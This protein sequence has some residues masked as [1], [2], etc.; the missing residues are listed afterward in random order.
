MSEEL[1]KETTEIKDD[2]TETHITKRRPRSIGRWLLYAV[3]SLVILLVLIALVAMLMLRTG[4]L[5]G[6]V[7]EQFI[8]KLNEIGVDFSADRFNVQTSPLELQ[9]ENGR[10]K[11]HKTGEDLLAVKKATIGL[12]V[13]DLFKWS[14]S[15]DISIDTTEVDGA[16]LW[17]KVDENG[18]SNFSDLNLVQKEGEGAVNFRYDSTR[19]TI[20]DSIVHFG[21]LSR[22]ISADANELNISLSPYTETVLG[23]GEE[24]LIDITSKKSTFQYGDSLI[25]DVSL[26]ASG[27]GR[28]DGFDLRQMVLTT[29]LGD[30][31]AKG[32]LSDFQSPKYDF[33]IDSNLDT[34]QAS[35]IFPVGASLKGFGTVK[36]HLTGEGETYKFEGDLTTEALRADGVYLKGADI[37]GTIMGTNSSYEANGKAVAELL[38]FDDFRLDMLKLA[39]N[40]RGTG[41]DFKWFGDLEAAAAK[42]G[43]LSI[44]G[45]YLRDALAEKRDREIR[46]SSSDGRAQKFAIGDTE[47]E[48]LRTRN[49]RFA[50]PDNNLDIRAENAT[51]KAFNT[52][53]YKLDQITGRN[54]VVQRKNGETSVT[55]AGLTSESSNIADADIKGLKAAEFKFIDRPLTTD[56]ELKG[57]TANRVN[58]DG[59]IIENPSA[60][61]ITINDDPQKTVI[62]SDATRVASVDAGGAVLGSMNVAGVRLLIK[63]GTVT[64]TS[65]DINAGTVDI[66]RSEAMANG[67]KLKEVTFKRP[68]FVVESGSRY[69]AT[70]DMSI[71][72]GTLGS[73]ALG[74]ATAKVTVDNDKAQLSDLKAS[75]MDGSI[76]GSLTYG[77][78]RRTTS[79]IDADFTDV[80]LSKLIA[81]N[82]GRAIPLEGRTRGLVALT[83]PGKDYRSASGNIDIKIAANTVGDETEKIPLNGDI[84]VA[85]VNGLF[86]IDTARLTTGMSEI[87]ATGRL[88]L[89]DNDTD[90]NVSL[91]SK[92][93]DEVQRLIKVSGLVPDLERRLDEM[94]IKA[95]GLMTFNGS[96]KGNIFDPL[97]EGRASLDQVS[98]SGRSLGSVAADIVSN[99]EGFRLNNGILNDGTGGT[100]NFDVNVPSIGT[101]NTTVNA[102]LNNVSA[103]GLLAALPI[104]LPKRIA[105]LSGRATGNVD[106]AGLPN[107]SIGNVDLRV[108][109]GLVAGQHFDE[110]TAKVSF[111]D[112]KIIVDDVRLKADGGELTANGNYDRGTDLFD[113]SAKGSDIL[114][115]ILLAALPENESI[116]TI[117]GKANLTARATGKAGDPQTYV[118]NFDG[119]A[120]AVQVAGSPFGDIGFAGNT[121]NRVLDAA[122]TATINGRKQIV[123]ARLDLGKENLPLTASTVF[124]QSPIE[125]FLAFIP[126]IKGI[127]IQGT[128]T[129]RIELSG[130][131]SQTGADGN[132]AVSVD[133]LS[134]TANFSSLGLQIMDTPL[135][136][137][138][139][140]SV[141]F[142]PKMIEVASA[143]FSGGGSNMTILGKKALAD[144]ESDDLGIFG[145]V[146]LSLVNL[147][148]KDTFYSGLADVS[149]RLSGPYGNS[150]ISGNASTENATFATFVGSDRLT[151]ERVKTRVIFTSSQA[152]IEEATGYLGGGRFTA[153]GGALL[154]GLS[155]QSF[156]FNLDGRG[157]TVPFPKDFVTTGDA[158]LEITGI[159]PTSSE[160]ISVSVAGRVNAS[161]SIY[162]KDIDLANIIGGR[163]ERSL[164]S[165]GGSSFGNVRFDLVVEGRDALIVRNNIADLTASVSL[166]VTGDA[167]E[168]MVSGRVIATGGTLFYRN[169]RYILQRGVVE[170]PPDRAIEPIVNLQ[171]ETEIGGYQIFLSLNGSLTETE[172]LSLNVRSSPSL[173]QADI[174]SLITTGALT[175]SNGGIPT[176]AQTGIRTAAELLTDSIINNPTRK[177]TDK[178]FGLNVFE[179]DPI[180]SGQQSNPGARLTVGRQINRNLRV[181]YA[182]NLSQDQNQVI[183]LE[184]RVSNRLSFIAQ[185]EQRSLTNVTRNRDNFSIELRFRKRF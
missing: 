114:L 77:F 11:N 156:R 45:L 64:I 164:S 105:D 106:I 89:K 161:R 18:R 21:D 108:E 168:P 15:R 80:D 170:F 136:A 60:P 66:K 123:N 55:A 8:A 42:K 139:P 27:L 185:Y 91:N 141:R 50:M 16:E 167:A 124:D 181:T 166:L 116:P 2:T 3:G 183:A 12:T 112:T 135:Q 110:L 176:F 122:L 180:I 103:S 39:G 145:R 165:G 71:G 127:P 154:N 81:L 26:K 41:T 150:R 59:T 62:Y 175:N 90:L 52:K 5:N 104:T 48:D 153:S 128:A 113:F 95:S 143:K 117:E 184:Y 30:L 155:P 22:K 109:N 146:D 54:V 120:N 19:L 169:D 84:S 86:E 44:A 51:A 182:T 88:D 96:V 94:N 40:V 72:G 43:K 29:P 53:H 63:E 37:D 49:L 148:T 70:A 97:I 38:T 93:A 111:A 61:N 147:F 14:L 34:A 162:R 177:A 20:R 73:F 83:F 151:F 178:L 68:I 129:G 13:V 100:A 31:T 79:K 10:F 158:R 35:R 160:P 137:V 130:D 28:K 7:K 144:G 138:E 69:R 99:D 75:V 98:L 126:Q 78:N 125:P 32:S 36:G 17:I 132:R 76:N 101:N 174:V 87:V 1:D 118:I 24:F 173:P 23:P 133:G 85:A 56:V 131:L 92:I 142:S 57:V 102:K 171:A 152:A 46:A 157:V 67:G 82:S 25:E 172:E 6:Y 9:I 58:I 121:V 140:V 74:A 107:K 134:G 159:R 119:S 4:A 33:D 149:V 179:I 163:R 47:F 65:G 115:P